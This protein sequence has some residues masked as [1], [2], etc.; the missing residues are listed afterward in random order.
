MLLIVIGES[1]DDERIDRLVDYELCVRRVHASE[2][3]PVLFV[4]KC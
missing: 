3:E 1:E 2:Q 4:R